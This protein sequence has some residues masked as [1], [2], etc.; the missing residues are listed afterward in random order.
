MTSTRALRSGAALRILSVFL[1]TV[2]SALIHALAG[3]ASLGQI[4]FW[5]S[6]VALLPICFWLALSG[7]FPR[8]L[9][10]RRPAVH[11]T[12]GAF[13][14]LSMALSFLSLIWLPVANAQALAY[15]A[16]VLTL[17]LAALMLGERP[18]ARVLIAVGLGFAGVMLILWQ[19]LQL[20]GRTALWGIAAGLGYALTMAFVRVH[21]K[22]MT[23]T[24]STASITFWFAVICAVIGL[25]LHPAPLQ[26][27]DGRALT[28]LVLAGLFGGAAHIASTEAVRRAPV[29]AV[30]P[31]DFTG[32]IW[33]L[34]IDLA[35]FGLLPGWMGLAGMMVILLAALLATGLLP[36]A[37]GRRDQAA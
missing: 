33:A 30:A 21:I 19:S 10:S 34:G 2:M 22:A 24:E 11:L 26:G 6:A 12:R 23:R 36:W 37:R 25:I 18:G 9:G 5:R 27:L 15:L 4:M 13:G 1:I 29:S 16:P 3:S 35:V 14:A 28:L 8:G 17:P 20:P 32:L 31:Y 7:N